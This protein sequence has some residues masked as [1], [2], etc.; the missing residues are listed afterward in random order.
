VL[1]RTT[2]DDVDLLMPWLTGFHRE[3]IHD[4]ATATEHE[5]FRGQVSR[6][7]LRVWDNNGPVSMATGTRPTRSGICVGAVYTPP[8]HRNRGYATSCVASL[9]E[10]LLKQYTFC[11]LYTD[12]SNPTS[13]AIYKRIGFE[14]YCDS[15]MYSYGRD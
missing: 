2:S 8:E 5:R 13:N 11:V 15:A 10:E 14:E 1:R 6:G 7:G 9:C 12:L 4:E 3:A